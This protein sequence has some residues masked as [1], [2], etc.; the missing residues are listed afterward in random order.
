MNRYAAWGL[1]AALATGA[2]A[3]VAGE[4]AD[5]TFADVPARPPVV[6]GPPEPAVLLEAFK[7]E[8]D[9]YLRRVDVCLKLREIAAA[10]GDEQL[11]RQAETL[12]RQ[13]FALYRQRVARLG[14]KSPHATAAEQLDHELSGTAK[15]LTVA[16]PEPARPAAPEAHQFREVKRD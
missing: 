11:A 16:P 4:P 3:L 9:A 12:D 15:S 14:V 1:S 6:Y 2:G 8:K 7:A 10:R 13:A 5:K